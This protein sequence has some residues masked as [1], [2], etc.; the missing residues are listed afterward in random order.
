MRAQE[1]ARALGR[2]KL[3]GECVVLL[4]AMSPEL[5]TLVHLGAHPQPPPQESPEMLP[6]STALDSGIK[7]HPAPLTL[8][9]LVRMSLADGVS[10]SSELVD[11][12]AFLVRTRPFFIGGA[13]PP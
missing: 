6:F 10:T 13:A 1:V 9:N 11:A 4:A 2:Q 3:T 7:S 12:L 8:E 5:S